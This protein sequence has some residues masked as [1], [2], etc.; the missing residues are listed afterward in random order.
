MDRKEED[1][2]REGAGGVDCC[3]L[4]EVIGGSKLYVC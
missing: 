2:R 4:R 1:G 3:R